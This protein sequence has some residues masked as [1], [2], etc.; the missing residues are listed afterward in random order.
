ML[1]LVNETPTHY[2]IEEYDNDDITI[3]TIKRHLISKEDVKELF[4]VINRPLK[5]EEIK[6]FQWIWNEDDKEYVEVCEIVSN[7]R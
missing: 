4:N 3:A 5:L 6:P 1:K 2:E 7:H